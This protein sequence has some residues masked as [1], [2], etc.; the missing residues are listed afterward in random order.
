MV[1]IVVDGKEY[2]EEKDIRVVNFLNSH[3]IT[4]DSVILGVLVNNEQKKSMH[5]CPR[6]HG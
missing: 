3:N 4:S 6:S 2:V 1:K 5:D